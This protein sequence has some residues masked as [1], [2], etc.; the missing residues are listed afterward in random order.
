MLQTKLF[1]GLYLAKFFNIYYISVKPFFPCI[2]FIV[3]KE[4]LH[5]K[6]N[7]FVKDL[8]F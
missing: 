1:S 2:L 4:R 5:G 6:R 7:D 8:K 3:E